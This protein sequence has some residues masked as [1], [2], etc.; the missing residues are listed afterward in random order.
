M[1]EK[2]FID[3]AILRL[4]EKAEEFRTIQLGHQTNADGAGEKAYHYE[5]AAEIVRSVVPSIKETIGD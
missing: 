3:E 1:P 4:R 5:Q 2:T